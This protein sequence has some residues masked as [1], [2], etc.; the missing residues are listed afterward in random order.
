M[1]LISVGVARSIWLFDINDLNPKGKN[2][3]PDLLIW[4]GEKYN[5][6]NFPKSLA[7]LDQE[8]KGYLFKTGE[9]Q[10]DEHA[11]QVNLS[12]FGDGVVAESWASTEK[13]D[14][15]LDEIYKRGIKVDYAVQ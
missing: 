9:F 15:F 8:K 5:F 7:D 3:L 4:L 11:I 6:Q 10:T 12:I 14:L 13:S 2:I 1:Q